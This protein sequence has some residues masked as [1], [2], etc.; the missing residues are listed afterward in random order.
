L[1]ETNRA[2][3]CVSQNFPSSQAGR[4]TG[5][6]CQRAHPFR[7]PQLLPYSK[8][9]AQRVA[10]S[11]RLKIVAVEFAA[12]W[13]K[14]LV[15]GYVCERECWI[16]TD[17]SK[18]SAEARRIDAKPFPALGTLAERK[19]HS[20]RGA[21]KSWPVGLLPGGL[22]EAWL[23]EHVHKVLLVEGGPDYLAACQL[24]AE[25][26]SIENILPVAMLGASATISSDALTHF[27]D[28]HVTVVAHGDDAGRTAGMRWATQVQA[29]AAKVR[30]VAMTTGDLCDAVTQG[31]TNKEL[32]LL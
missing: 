18:R 16:I 11:R 20:L 9:L 32:G 5:R 22:E 10:D 29:V 31:A 4:E 15:F 30:L 25:P 7:V 23:R 13:L 2:G 17:A 12:S 24:I 8:E 26:E 28:R 27:R 19:S 1:Q 3:G 14:T 21:K 6:T